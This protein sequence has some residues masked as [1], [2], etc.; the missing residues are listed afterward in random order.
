ANLDGLLVHGARRR[1]MWVRAGAGL[2]GGD[3]VVRGCAFGGVHAE[4]G[5]SVDLTD[6]VLEDNMYFG[7]DIIAAH[8]TFTRLRAVGTRSAP[9]LSFVSGA[10]VYA[11]NGSTLVIEQAEIEDS[12]T[13]GVM[14]V[15]PGTTATI[16][17]TLVRK[18]SLD[19]IGFGGGPGL[20]A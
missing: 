10:G 20:F 5:G 16:A 14:L 9:G 8:G 3:V 11:A 18:T 12:F 7:T 6:L 19:P 2:T 1:G 17:D 15:N 4:A 13:A